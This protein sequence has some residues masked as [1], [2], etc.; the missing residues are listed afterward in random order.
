M[1]PDE[2]LLL[3]WREVAS[4]L[5]WPLCARYN[6]S[7]DSY[8]QIIPTVEGLALKLVPDPRIP[9][10]PTAAHEKGSG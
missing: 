9:T 8:F 3:P 5:S 1:N 2:Y 7:E 6:L 10:P 4:L